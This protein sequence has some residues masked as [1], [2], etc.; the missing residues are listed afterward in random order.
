MVQEEEMISIILFILLNLF[1]IEDIKFIQKKNTKTIFQINF[2]LIQRE[3]KE[4][5]ER[6]IS[7]K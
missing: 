1:Q 6:N 5:K 4:R 7:T 2:K 3:T